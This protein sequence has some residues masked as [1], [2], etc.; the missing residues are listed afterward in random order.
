MKAM[1]AYFDSE[2]M[3]TRTAWFQLSYRGNE[4]WAFGDA[5]NTSIVDF[6]TG[7]LTEIGKEW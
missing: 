3:I 4:P 2:P 1:Q 6:D 7:E 5:C